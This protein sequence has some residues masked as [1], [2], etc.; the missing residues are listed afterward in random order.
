VFVPPVSQHLG[1][2]S[3]LLPLVMHVCDQHVVLTRL[4]VLLG[5]G[6]VQM[7][8]PSLSALLRRPEVSSVRVNVQLFRV[9]T[10]F[11]FLLALSNQFRK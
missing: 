8:E 9:L 6:G 5:L 2:L 11:G 7:I 10:P 4:P 1:D 3:P